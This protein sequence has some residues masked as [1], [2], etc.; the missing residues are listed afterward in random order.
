M[1]HVCI[2]PGFWRELLQAAHTFPPPG[3]GSAAARRFAA[4]L[5]RRGVPHGP[6]M[7]LPV[8]QADA[9]YLDA[10]LDEYLQAP[11]TTP[12]RAAHVRTAGRLRRDLAPVLAE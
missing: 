10:L 2:P 8:D 9:E 11:R 7:E 5:R 3:F 6:A 4:A 1:T 12:Q